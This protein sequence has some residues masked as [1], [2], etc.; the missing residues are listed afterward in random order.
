M[1]KW[2]NKELGE[3]VLVK[4]CNASQTYFLPS[5]ICKGK[6]SVE[7]KNLQ[8]DWNAYCMK[9][10]MGL[11]V[12]SNK[13]SASISQKFKSETNFLIK[14]PVSKIFIKKLLILILMYVTLCTVVVVC[15]YKSN[16]EHISTFLDIKDIK[17]LIL[18]AAFT[19][20][21]I[22]M[23]ENVIVIWWLCDSLR[24]IKIIFVL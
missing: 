12:F 21:I 1:T 13:I 4:F 20:N 3:W 15:K 19:S 10:S 9:Y 17:I 11:L 8:K 6:C 14:H 18:G 5:Q 2:L 22:F 16:Q 7:K 23:A 24:T